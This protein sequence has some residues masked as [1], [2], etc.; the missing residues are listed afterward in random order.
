MLTH[1][2]LKKNNYEI[3]RKYIDA[4]PPLSPSR[5]SIKLMAFIVATIISIVNTSD[6]TGILAKLIFNPNKVTFVSLSPP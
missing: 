6:K 3:V 2:Y 5:P 1:I 4:I